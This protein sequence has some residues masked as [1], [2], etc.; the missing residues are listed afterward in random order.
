MMRVC[1]VT[2]AV[3]M[4]ILL[5]WAGQVGAS[6]RISKI[7]VAGGTVELTVESVPGMRY[8]VQCRL[9]LVEGE[10]QNV[11]PE[12]IPVSD[13]EIRTVP[14]DGGHCNYRVVEVGQTGNSEPTPPPPPPPPPS[15]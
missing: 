12:F 9:S 13:A 15:E 4:L 2:H 5:V 6:G 8:Q 3:F 7:R 14:A 1:R 11:G 10:W